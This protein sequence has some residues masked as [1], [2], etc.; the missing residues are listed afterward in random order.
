MEIHTAKAEGVVAIPVEVINT[1]MEGDF[2]FVAEN[3]MVVK[4]RITTGITSDS[5][6]EV[7]EGLTEG[8]AVIMTMGQELEEGMSVTAI[9]QN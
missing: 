7:K 8:E 4:K 3:G 1:D 6:S 9:P 5:Y 2:V